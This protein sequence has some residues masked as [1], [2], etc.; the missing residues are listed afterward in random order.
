MISIHI[1]L[2]DQ[3][4]SLSQSEEGSN[5]S[6][7]QNAIKGGVVV[8]SSGKVEDEE[9]KQVSKLE[10]RP[11]STVISYLN[12]PIHTIPYLYYPCRS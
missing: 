11:D 3:L 4:G 5:A 2:D 10:V 9:A 8:G 12:S 7:Q 1:Q 6:S